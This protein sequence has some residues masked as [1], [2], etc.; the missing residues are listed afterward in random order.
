MI[1]DGMPSVAQNCRWTVSRTNREYVE[2]VSKLT[3]LSIHVSQTLIN[4]NIKTAEQIDTFL[5]PCLSK[6]ADPY[7]LQGMQESVRRIKAAVS[8]KER[9]LVHGDYDADGVTATAIMVEALR[10]IGA[11]VSYFIPDRSSGYGLGLE[12]VKTARDAGVSLI[13]T[14]DCGITSFEAVSAARASGIDVVITD[15]HE[16]YSNSGKHEASISVEVPFVLPEACAIIDPKLDGGDSPMSRLSGAGVALK[17]AQ[18]LLG[19]SIDAVHGLMDLAALGTAADVV[20][21]TGDNRVMLKEGFNLIHAGERAGIRALKKISEMKS[22]GVKA[23]TLQYTLVPRINAAGRISNATDVVKLLLTDNN[24]EAEQLAEWLNGLNSRRQVIGE[25]VLV[26]AMEI[27]RASGADK[28]DAIVVGA[29][30]WHPGVLGIVAAKL[31]DAFYRP[32]FVFSVKDGIAKGSARSIPPF[33]VHS[34]L[35]SCNSLLINF[36]GH[37][38]AAGLSLAAEKLDEFR[39]AISRVVSNTVAADDL[40]PVLRIDASM[41]LQDI[42][43]EL[44]NDISRLE[45]FGFDNEEPVFGARRLEISQTRLVGKNHLKMQLRQDGK[46]MDSIGFDFGDMLNYL[47]KGDLVDV[48]FHPVMNEWEGGRGLQMNLRAVRPSDNGI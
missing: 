8:S 19:N 32:A 39:E 22:S 1:G 12:G 13:I 9:I 29:E 36:G 45:P 18:A 26:Q 11:E 17:L 40:S 28:Y 38:Q 25:T 4:R 2:Y 47:K 6:L 5:N 48:A 7:T 37:K 21:V 27:I 33:D 41:R 10:K 34:G 31:V 14:V 42:N 16:P 35:S 23:S 44:I 20:P 3:G 15:H 24:S 43:N 46:C 30:G